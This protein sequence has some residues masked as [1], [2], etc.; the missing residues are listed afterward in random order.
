VPSQRRRYGVGVASGLG[1]ACAD[2]F[3]GALAAFGATAVSQALLTHELWLELSGGA[4][5]VVIGIR[6][7]RRPF[8]FVPLVTRCS[9]QVAFGSMFLLTL[10][11]PMTVLAFVAL[12]AALGL[13]TVGSPSAALVTV[14]GVFLGSALWWLTVASG[15]DLVRTRVGPRVLVAINRV[16]GAII[17]GFGLAVVVAALT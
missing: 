10:A 6:S 8:A 15:I 11:N 14:T 9:A 1:V 16:A 13:A 12:S 17:A 3:Y 4:F 5:L 7:P 2:T